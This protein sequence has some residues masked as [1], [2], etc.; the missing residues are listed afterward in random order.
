[1]F[2]H[3]TDDR[4]LPVTGPLPCLPQIGGAR[5]A[6]VYDLGLPWYAGSQDSYV[7]DLCCHVPIS[8]FRC[9]AWS[10]IV[11]QCCMQT[12]RQMGRRTDGRHARSTTATGE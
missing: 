6:P 3:M 9:T 10:V 8:T 7:V 5:T 4:N 12:D 11:H 2:V 1:M